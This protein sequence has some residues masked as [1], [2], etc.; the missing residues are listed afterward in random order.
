[1]IDK[2]KLVT[3]HKKTEAGDLLEGAELELIEDA[4]NTVLY[5]FTS[6]AN[7]NSIFKLKNGKYT[8]HEKYAP[9]NY[10]IADDIHFEVTDDTTEVEYTMVDEYT[11]CSLKVVK[12]DEKTQQP[13]AGVEFT[14]EGANGQKFTATTNADGEAVFGVVDGKSTLPPQKYTLTE[15]KS[16]SGYS[17]LKD[18]V[19]IELPLKLTEA[20]ATA[21][22]AD[23]SKGKW[24]KENEVY[25]FFDVTYQVSDGATFEL[26]QTGNNS[27]LFSIIGGIVTTI[28]TCLYFYLQSK[29]RKVK[30]VSRD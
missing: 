22:G 9:E 11:G 8:L 23:L 12:V 1:M 19:E 16:K 25:R 24:D 4:T 5:T 14:L 10:E 13:L 7:V 18:P 29:R 3:I 27:I 30:A 6:S 28:L 17:L 26:P 15:S 2:P 21:Y 20:E